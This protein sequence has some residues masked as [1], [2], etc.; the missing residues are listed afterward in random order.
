MS[1]FFNLPPRIL[2]TTSRFLI[3]ASSI[4][5]LVYWSENAITFSTDEVIFNHDKWKLHC[6]QS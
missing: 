3:E 4:A 5:P 1:K 6:K 2:L